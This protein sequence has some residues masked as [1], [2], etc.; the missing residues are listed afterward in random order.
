MNSITLPITPIRELYQTPKLIGTVIDSIAF[1][2]P[3]PNYPSLAH[4]EPSSSTVDICWEH[5]CSGWHPPGLSCSRSCHWKRAD[6]CAEARRRY[7]GLSDPSHARERTA[8]GMCPACG[9]RALSKRC[10]FFWLK[11]KVNRVDR[12]QRVFF[13]LLWVGL[14]LKSKEFHFYLT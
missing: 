11:E 6:K 13:I 1:Q 2:S 10:L 12:V 5:S 3:T 9:R 7:W 4:S 8:C 14:E